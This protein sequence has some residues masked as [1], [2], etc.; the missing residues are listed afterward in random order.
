MDGKVLD[1]VV[2]KIIC[3]IKLGAGCFINSK[4]VI[5]CNHIL[6]LITGIIFASV[7]YTFIFVTF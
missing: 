3:L 2:A 6:S 5:K 4:S 7:T 1:Y